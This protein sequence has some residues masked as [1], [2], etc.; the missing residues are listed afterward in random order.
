M[1]LQE[2]GA[3]SAAVKDDTNDSDS[4]GS[5][6]R[7]RRVVEMGCTC[8]AFLVQSNG[9]EFRGGQGRGSRGLCLIR[10]GHAGGRNGGRLQIDIGEKKQQ[11][12]RNGEEGDVDP[13]RILRQAAWEVGPAPRR[14]R[15]GEIH[16]LGWAVVEH[17]GGSLYDVVAVRAKRTNSLA[18]M[19]QNGDDAL[20]A[21]SQDRCIR[22]SRIARQGRAGERTGERRKFPTG[23]KKRRSRPP[24]PPL[25]PHRPMTAM[26]CGL[27]A[28]G[29][30]IKR[31]FYT[32]NNY[33]IIILSLNCGFTD[34]SFIW[35][36]SFSLFCIVP[37][38]VSTHPVTILL[39]SL[40]LAFS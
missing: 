3:V 16:R 17:L 8:F 24:Q 26:C 19:R 25:G 12:A 29:H 5:H 15:V 10:G 31:L 7:S 30:D 18:W 36:L 37:S 20:Y 9:R 38:P 40:L 35:S 23:S 21:H 32:T 27:T 4:V 39:V 1:A 33:Y 28:S 22:Y 11:Q 34:S 13:S 2:R 6:E 14:L